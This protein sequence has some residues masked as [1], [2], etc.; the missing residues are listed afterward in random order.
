VFYI[1]LFNGGCHVHH[2]DVHECI[3]SGRLD[4]G[5]GLTQYVYTTI[6]KLV[7][8]N[9]IEPDLEKIQV[10][11]ASVYIPGKRWKPHEKIDCVEL[12]EIL[13]KEY[14]DPIFEF[15]YVNDNRNLRIFEYLCE[16]N[17]LRVALQ[18]HGIKNPLL[19]MTAGLFIQDVDFINTGKFTTNFSRPM[20]EPAII[21][22]L[23]DLKSSL[24][25]DVID[26]HLEK[27]LPVLVHVDI[28]HMPYER[29]HYYHNRHGAHVVSLLG[30]CDNEYVM[31]DW[32]HPSYYY[33]EITKEDLT[34]A[35]TSTNEK[36]QT[37]VFN[38]YPIKSTY[39]LLHLERFP[40]SLDRAQ[41]VAA[42]LYRSVKYLLDDN[43]II[44]CF[45]QVC[46]SVPKW[47][48]IP[49]HEGYNNAIE[50]L[51]FLD[52]ELKFLLLYYEEMLNSDLYKQFN[53]N[54]LMEKIVNIR[55]V[56]DLLKN[57]LIL[58]LRRNTAIE[59]E[60]WVELLNKVKRHI[61]DYCEVVLKLLRSFRNKV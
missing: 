47:L 44:S 17:S 4:G 3:I 1:N 57:K 32:A 22:V 33:G 50:S 26:A 48:K 23:G 20:L 24:D 31:L 38:G 13:K 61:S 52:L 40:L 60:I 39:Q 36:D 41:Y 18:G 25:W 54:V 11:K 43:G 8:S 15:E 46:L 49:G 30:K 12:S 29:N 34:I 6:E 16:R 2:V 21:P 9:Y 55:K 10:G 56:V 51:F 14:H 35:R 53:P 37:S 58:A 45:T 19:W 5:D 42:N 59:E 27:R 7:I 28:Y